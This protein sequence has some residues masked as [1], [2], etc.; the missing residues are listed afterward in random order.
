M[1]RGRSRER[2]ANR[3]GAIGLN[4]EIG[5]GA[6]EPAQQS[7]DDVTI[8]VVDRAVRQGRPGLA[9]LVAGREDG[10]AQTAKDNEVRETERCGET[11]LLRT[12]PP[13]GT[14]DGGACGNVFA[15]AAPVGP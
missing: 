8:G 6:A 3:R 2:V 14:D 9:K 12:Q 5:C 11:E 10:D 1:I 4:A 15:G 13:A 7:G